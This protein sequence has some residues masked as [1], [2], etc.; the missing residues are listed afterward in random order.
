[1]KPNH[2]AGWLFKS[3]WFFALTSFSIISVALVS[4]HS[5]NDLNN[6]PET[7]KTLSASTDFI[8]SFNNQSFI[9][10]LSD[11]DQ[12]QIHNLYQSFYEHTSQRLKRS[13]YLYYS[14]AFALLNKWQAKYDILTDLVLKYDKKTSSYQFTLQFKVKIN[15]L[16]NNL[17][18]ITKP[19]FYTP[20]KDNSLPTHINNPQPYWF[21]NKEEIIKKLEQLLQMIVV[22]KDVEIIPTWAKTATNNQVLSAFSFR[23]GKLSRWVYEANQKSEVNDG[24]AYI[25]KIALIQQKEIDHEVELA[26][27]DDQIYLQTFVINDS[28]QL[29]D[30]KKI[31]NENIFQYALDEFRYDVKDFMFPTFFATDQSL[32]SIK[33]HQSD[34]TN[35]KIVQQWT[36]NNVGRINHINPKLSSIIDKK[37]ILFDPYYYFDQTF[38]PEN[39]SGI[40][41][42]HADGYCHF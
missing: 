5:T 6:K 23:K 15:D 40:K 10:Q 13:F 19:Q 32:L 11:D 1:M 24:F 42:C 21:L 8:Y 17:D 36:E 4:C 35:T 38:E 16:G 22:Y 26:T 34:K 31:T 7:F 20:T 37:W 14:F 27:F 33:H 18:A 41:H 30:V 12:K 29:P 39:Q 9:N 25:N 2:S 28:N 3:K